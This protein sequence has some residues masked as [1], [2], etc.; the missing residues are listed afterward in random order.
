M[1]KNWKITLGWTLI[2]TLKLVIFFFFKFFRRGMKKKSCPKEK[3]KKGLM[4]AR[5][6]QATHAHTRGLYKIIDSI[7]DLLW[8]TQMGTTTTTTTTT[9]S[10][11]LFLLILKKIFFAGVDFFSPFCPS[12]IWSIHSFIHHNP[13]V[14]PFKLINKF[15]DVTIR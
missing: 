14:H 5:S 4:M 7:C 1:W 12:C 10:L 3:K 9:T 2:K 6:V 15:N 11:I 8:T 13:S